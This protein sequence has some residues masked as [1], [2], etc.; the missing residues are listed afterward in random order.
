MSA[1]QGQGV[2]SIY[3]LSVNDPFVMQAWAEDMEVG[4][5]L[6]MIADGLAD[7]TKALSMDTYMCDRWACAACVGSADCSSHC[8]GLVPPRRVWTAQIW[9]W[10]GAPV[11]AVFHGGSQRCGASGEPGNQRR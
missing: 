7:L 8:P 5:K 6:E 2:D 1:A 4:S 10:H 3:C 11:Q 9:R